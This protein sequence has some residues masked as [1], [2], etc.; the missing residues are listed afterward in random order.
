MYRAG[1][2][3]QRRECTELITLVYRAGVDVQRRECT[4]EPPPCRRLQAPPE[5]RLWYIRQPQ[6]EAETDA[7]EDG[8]WYGNIN[9]FMYVPMSHIPPK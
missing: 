2:Y 9:I 3:V 4:G 7:Q 5:Q 8:H 1:V 6:Q